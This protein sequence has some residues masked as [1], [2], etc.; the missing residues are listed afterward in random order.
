[1][2]GRVDA[3]S[4]GI[5]AG[6]RTVNSLSCNV[7]QAQFP[8]IHRHMKK[9]DRLDKTTLAG[10][11][12]QTHFRGDEHNKTFVTLRSSLFGRPDVSRSS[13]IRQ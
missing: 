2:D 8:V 12:V 7:E 10:W 11:S 6:L 3:R 5:F 13:C 9:G 4:R 1:M